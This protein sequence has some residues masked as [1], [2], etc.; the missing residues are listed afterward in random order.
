VP[1]E[2]Q[3]RYRNQKG[4]LSQNVLAVCNFDISF[5]YILLGWEGFAHNKRVLLDAQNRYSFDTPKGKY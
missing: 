2:E 1:L 3:L 4:T 5:V